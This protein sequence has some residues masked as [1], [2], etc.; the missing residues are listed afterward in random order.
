MSNAYL[1]V[2]TPEKFTR[3][4]VTSFLDT[5]EG[6]EQWFYSI[7]NSIFIVGT[8]PARTLSKMLMEKFGEH[9]H[10]ITI[11]SKKARAGWMPKDHWRLLPDDN[12]S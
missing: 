5:Q 6:V 12:A 4:Q 9:R 11:I 7:P 1:Y 2:F 8:I 10:F 3:E